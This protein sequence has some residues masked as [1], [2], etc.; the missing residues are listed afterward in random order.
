[1]A[2]DQPGA[3]LTVLEWAEERR[4]NTYRLAA[5]KTGADRDGWL[6]DA[7][8]WEQIVAVLAEEDQRRAARPVR[9]GRR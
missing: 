4:A 3:A 6:E 1:M 9:K 2:D 7:A 5:T 8:Y